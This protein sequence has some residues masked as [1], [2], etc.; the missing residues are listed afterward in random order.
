MQP[1]T[2]QPRNPND[3]LIFQNIDNEDHEWQY[4]A[5][6]TPLPYYIRAGETRKLPFYIARHGVEKLIDKMLGKKGIVHTNPLEREKLRKQ[7]V[8]GVEQ[9]N[10]VRQKT[11][12]ELALEAMQRKKDVDPYEE[13]FKEREIE[14]EQRASQLQAS[15]QSTT[16]LLETVGTPVAPP[17]AVTTPDPVIPQADPERLKVYQ[18]LTN[19]LH[20]DLNHE[21]TREKLDSMTVD[22]IRK[23]FS[24]Q[25]PS[26]ANPQ[27]T[28]VPDS[29]TAPVEDGMPITASVTP[30]TPPPPPAAPVQAPSGPTTTPILDQQIAGAVK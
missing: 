8:L 11:E 20:L 9:I 25:L 18:M 3:L 24:D 17:P 12:N 26:L 28:I 1:E 13:L 10:F 16:P 30:N 2:P 29:K 5:I 23:E 22:A 4:D 19:S 14:A 6:K 27:A 15:A 21:K 7:I